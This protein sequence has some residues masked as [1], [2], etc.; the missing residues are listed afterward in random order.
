MTLQG[1]RAA[2][3]AHPI[4]ESGAGRHWRR[5]E[6]DGALLS[7]PGSGRARNDD[8]SVFAAPGHDAAEAAAAGYLFAVI[9][10]DAQQPNACAAARETATSL[11]ETLE[12]PRRVELRPD[13]IMHRMLDANDRCERFIRG[14]CAATCVWLWEELAP[15]RVH[16]AWAHVGHTRLC[17]H[18]GRRWRQLTR[19]HARGPLLDRAVGQGAGLTVDTGRC[20]LADGQ[21]LVLMTAGVWRTGRLGEVL[22]GPDFPHA[23]EMVRRLVGQARLNGSRDDT[24]AIAVSVHAIDES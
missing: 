13:L 7:A 20:E 15:D 8:A 24:S 2:R 14:R 1:K 5:F 19:D 11:L 4:I 21:R 18:D 9:D 17:L 6:L 22:P 10:G 16:A 3:K 23:S 12:D